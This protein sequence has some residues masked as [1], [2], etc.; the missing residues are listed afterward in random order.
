MLIY[1]DIDGVMVQGKS[2]RS[3]EILE[4]GFS[5]FGVK[6]VKSL[7]KIISETN[8]EIVLTTSHKHKYS[9][10]KWVEFF[11]RRNIILNNIS[12]LPENTQRL[13]R[14]EE[15]M[16]W[17]NSIN[18][19]EEF[20]IIDDDKSLNG[21]TPFY[22]KRLLQTSASIGLTEYLADEILTRIKESNFESA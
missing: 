8:A 1:L 21:L 9:L 14:R 5:E 18:T 3:P 17:F 10:E 22:K 6:A 4:D 13:N 12:R 15:L 20:I 7:I 19:D 2:W 16:K 11:K